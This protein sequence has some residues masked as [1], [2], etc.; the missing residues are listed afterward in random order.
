MCLTCTSAMGRGVCV[1]PVLVL[2]G[3][4]CL[5]CTSAAGRGV[6]LTCTN[7]M[8]RGVC[9]SPVLV[10]WGEVCVSPV[11]ELWGEVCVSPVLVHNVEGG[12]QQCNSWQNHFALSFATQATNNL[13]SSIGK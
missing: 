12:N 8:G 3:E 7:A 2:W 5:T 10:L 9:V 4:V 1:S 13:C 6:C 11:L